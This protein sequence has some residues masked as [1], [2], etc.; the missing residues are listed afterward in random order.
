MITLKNSGKIMQHVNFGQ[1]DIQIAPLVFG[2]NVFGWTIDKKQSFSMID[3][4]L[5][6][7]INML[8]TANVYSV[9]AEGNEGGESESII[10]DWLKQSG[11]RDKIVIA[12]KVGME[13]GDG[14]KGLSYQNI[15]RSAEASLKRLNTDYIDVF[16]AH[17]DDK[18]VPLEESLTAF[19]ELIKEGKVRT[20]A[21]SNYSANRLTEAL[22]VSQENNLPRFIAHQPQYNLFDREEYEGELE[23]VCTEN[24][25]GVVTYFSMA[26]GF[27][28]GKYKSSEDVKKSNR[29]EDFIK[30][31]MTTRGEKILSALEVVADQHHTTMAATALA[32]IK[33]R[34]SIT[35][36][37]ASATSQ[38]QLAQLVEAAS[39]RLS[40]EDI[41]QLNSAS[42]Y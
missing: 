42:E 1:S 19:D 10:G 8:D 17:A 11:S 13:M 33:A 22:T 31:Y 2:T 36:P 34:Y 7:D 27:L 4:L 26:S 20:I 23:R 28:T 24:S 39:L 12:T 16:Y 41:A 21:S 35:A 3:A 32:W 15:I 38:D 9:W 18:S 29:G 14:S 25:L 6:H 30:K 5:S 40:E 37:V